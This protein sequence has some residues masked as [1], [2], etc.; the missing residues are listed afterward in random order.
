MHL[1]WSTKKISA[2]LGFG[3]IETTPL[4]RSRPLKTNP[5]KIISFMTEYTRVVPTEKGSLLLSQLDKKDTSDTRKTS[6]L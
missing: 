1:A 5:D 6:N 3:A 4:L 2:M